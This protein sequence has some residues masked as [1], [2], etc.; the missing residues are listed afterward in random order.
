MFTDQFNV[1]DAGDIHP[2]MQ[3][4][5]DPGERDIPARGPG[6]DAYGNALSIV[7]HDL[8]GPLA[9]LA[10]LVED[11][12]QNLQAQTQPRI[13]RNAAKAEGIIRQLNKMLGAVLWRAREGRDPLACELRLVDPLEIL[14]LAVSVNQPLARRRSIGFLCRAVEPVSVLGDQQLLFEAFDNLIGNAIKHTRAGGTVICEAG[15]TGDGGVYVH[16]GDEGPGFTASDLARAFN[17]FTRLSSRA[18]A[19]GQSTGL[20]LWITRLIVERHGGRIEARNRPDGAGAMLS[21]R[22]PAVHAALAD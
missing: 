7:A 19:S 13:A 15:P 3:L 2:A 8:R 12:S 6:H 11:I 5:E 9:N 16:I 18:Q 21:V 10:I 20:G 14:Q 22:L 17:P 4:R 1:Q